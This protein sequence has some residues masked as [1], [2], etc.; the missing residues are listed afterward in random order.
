MESLL[1]YLLDIA[2]EITKSK[3]P[4]RVKSF[5]LKLAWEVET[6]AEAIEVFPDMQICPVC[7]SRVDKDG[8]IAH[9]FRAELIN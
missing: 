1:P 3:E 5:Y 8:V 7:M 4:D 6:C 9:K 2:N